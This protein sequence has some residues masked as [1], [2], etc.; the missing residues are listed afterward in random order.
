VSDRVVFAVTAKQM[1]ELRAENAR[2]TAKLE[3]WDSA[4]PSLIWCRRAEAL[5]AENARLRE[6]VSRAIELIEAPTD[7]CGALIA[8][9]VLR[10]A[11][12]GGG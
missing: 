12:E 5:E 8:G 9:E 2:L 11:L 6:A 4:H 10:D 7:S 1:T 3:A